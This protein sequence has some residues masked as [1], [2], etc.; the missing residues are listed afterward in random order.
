[1][2]SL[3]RLVVTDFITEFCG[4]GITVSHTARVMQ[5][6]VQ[7]LTLGC[8]TAVGL[9]IV[10]LSCFSR[11]LEVYID[12]WRDV[13]KES[14]YGNENESGGLKE[15]NRENGPFKPPDSYTRRCLAGQLKM[16]AALLMKTKC[17][18]V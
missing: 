10:M 16:I 13:G 8:L 6:V 5:L 3:K 1:M 18:E 14:E 15:A 2:V 7:P 4:K 12:T 17:F 9:D 11:S